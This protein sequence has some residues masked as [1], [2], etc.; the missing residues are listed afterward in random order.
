[1]N[2]ANAGKWKKNTKIPI[3][4]CFF[5]PPRRII[6]SKV[7]FQFHFNEKSIENEKLRIFRF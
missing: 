5:Y 1:M 7:N 3:K 4:K 2:A 6:L